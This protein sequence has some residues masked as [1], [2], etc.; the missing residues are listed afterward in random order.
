MSVPIYFSKRAADLSI[1]YEGSIAPLPDTALG[2]W[3]FNLDRW[4][5]PKDLYGKLLSAADDAGRI[6]AKPKSA[7]EGDLIAFTLESV[8]YGAV[9]VLTDHERK[10]P[11]SVFLFQG[12]A[13]QEPFSP[14]VVVFGVGSVE[15]Y[16][17][18]QGD[19]KP[20]R[21]TWFPSSPEGRAYVYEKLGIITPTSRDRELDLLG[22][23]LSEVSASGEQVELFKDLIRTLNNNHLETDWGIDHYR[24]TAPRARLIG[25]VEDTRTEADLIEVLVRPVLLEQK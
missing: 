19:E 7:V 21:G 11:F 3:R 9:Q 4:L 17:D 5:K 23:S 13:K 15:N 8:I 16:V 2:S 24:R 22:M 1:S 14:P 12:M 25:I 6:W 10:E 18:F 20:F